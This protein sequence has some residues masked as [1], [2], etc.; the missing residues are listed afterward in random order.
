[1][2]TTTTTPAT[3]DALTSE[4]V[5]FMARPIPTTPEAWKAYWADAK[6]LRALGWKPSHEAQKRLDFAFRSG[7]KAG[8]AARF[9][10]KTG[11][12]KPAEPA[13][14]AAKQTLRRFRRKQ[15]AK[16]NH[17]SVA[18]FYQA[19]GQKTQR[20]FHKGFPGTNVAFPAIEQT[21]ANLQNQAKA[22]GVTQGTLRVVVKDWLNRQAFSQV[23]DLDRKTPR[24][25]VSGSL[26]KAKPARNQAA[27]PAKPA[28]PAKVEQKPVTPAV[29]SGNEAVKTALTAALQGLAACQAAIQAA[30]QAL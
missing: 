3:T 1:M 18:W 11:A 21:L 30:I 5:D 2:T 9:E 8:L 20:V 6:A 4:V 22:A 29:P 7:R 12:A 24:F 27:H 23:F 13:K 15:A 17:A 14:T 25:Q 19:N 28:K 16:G 10:A 26:R